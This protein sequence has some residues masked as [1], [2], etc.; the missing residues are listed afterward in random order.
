VC[1]D[2]SSNNVEMSLWYSLSIVVREQRLIAKDASHM[3]GVWRWAVDYW[4]R[5]ILGIPRR[6]SKPL[7][8]CSRS[9]K[10]GL[11]ASAPEGNELIGLF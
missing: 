2:G 1:I 4:D 9:W 7:E 3:S 6:N 10:S 8:T 11:C 5:D